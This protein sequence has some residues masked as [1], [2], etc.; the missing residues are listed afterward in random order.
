MA[1][2]AMADGGDGDEDGE[3]AGPEEGGG[4]VTNVVMR[5]RSNASTTEPSQMP[6]PAIHLTARVAGGPQAAA[7]SAAGE[8]EPS[9][10]C[11]GVG[12]V[13]RAGSPLEHRE[14]KRA[15]GDGQTHQPAANLPNGQQSQRPPAPHPAAAGVGGHA[16]RP[17]PPPR[18]GK[19]V[20]SSAAGDLGVGAGV[21]ASGGQGSRQVRQDRGPSLPPGWKSYGNGVDVR[22]PL[23]TSDASRRLSKAII[24]RTVTHPQQVTDMIQRQGAEPNVMPLLRVEGTT[25]GYFPYPLLSLCVDN[26]TDNRLPSIWAADDGGGGTPVAMPTWK[27]PS[28]QLAV[29]RSLIQGGADVNRDEGDHRPIV[30]AIASC[31]PAAFDLLMSRPGIQLQ[32]RRVA[33]L[34]RTLPTDQPS[35][36]HEATLLSFYRQPVDQRDPTLATERGPGDGNPLHRAA[37][38]Y[39]VWSQQFIEDYIDLLVANGADI[40]AVSSSGSTPLRFAAITGSHCVAASLCRRLPAADINRGTQNNPACTPLTL[41]AISLDDDTQRL[42]DDNTEQAERDRVTIRISNLKTTIRVLLQVGADIALMPTATEEDRRGRQLVLPEYATVLNNLPNDV[43]AAINAALAPQRSLAALLAPRLAVGPQEAPIF[44]WRIAS[45][46]FDMDA[47]TQTITEAI[48]VRHS[49]MAHRVR[50]SVE[51]FVRSAVYEAS[52]NRE[53]VGGMADV[54]GETVRVPLQC[55]A[56]NAGQQGSGQHRQLGVR[57][58]VHRARLDEAAQHGVAGLVKGFNEYLGNDDCQFQWQQLGCVERG[59]DGIA[60][61]RPLQLT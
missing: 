26:L 53:V 52:S 3:C 41:A 16:H 54:G 39:P 42:R 2:P 29:M 50:A 48:G 25:S 35:E 27:T 24:R 44:A 11:A 4:A 28:L 10:S 57:E 13:K 40:T 51:H 8:Q 31:N 18:V 58:V 36:A 6:S 1:S 21:G 34:P 20:S 19:G 47:A 37:A 17:P 30:V 38:S 9:S 55:F 12:V 56:I 22:L 7:A 61:F 15:K 59:R 60:T 49:A 32:G 43:M 23:G 46:L 5:Q 45:Y 14:P 33:F